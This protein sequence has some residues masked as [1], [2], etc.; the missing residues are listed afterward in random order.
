MT[1]LWIF[2]RLFIGAALLYSGWKNGTE[3]GWNFI[4]S[5]FLLGG[6]IVFFNGTNEFLSRFIRAIKETRQDSEK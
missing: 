6:I 3:H 1:L 5:L 2:L 4:Y